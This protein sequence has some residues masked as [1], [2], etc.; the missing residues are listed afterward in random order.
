M[1][2]GGRCGKSLFYANVGMTPVE[3]LGDYPMLYSYLRII[4]DQIS[5]SLICLKIMLKNEHSVVLG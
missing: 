1:S 4:H 5:C 3:H 2:Q